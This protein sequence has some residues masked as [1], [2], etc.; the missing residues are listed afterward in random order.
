MAI[1]KK[2]LKLLDDNKVK[3]EVVEHRKVY[4]ALDRT[5]TQKQDPKLT[6]KTLV[7]KL[8]SEHAIAM[9]PANKN[10]DTAKFKKVV[11]TARKKAGEKAI[12]KISFAKEPWMKKNLIGKVGATPPFGS[13]FKMP[14]YMDGPLLNQKK[15][16]VSSGEYTES[17]EIK[18]QD[19]LKLEPELIKGSFSKKK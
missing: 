9:L 15:L 7:M 10:L 16:Q 8:D 13:L 2:L 17:I 11:N 4:T 19:L 5:A 12:K 6:A 14:T 1:P 18:S 3:Y